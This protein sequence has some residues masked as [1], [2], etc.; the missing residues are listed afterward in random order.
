MR[1]GVDYPIQFDAF[2]LKQQK[3]SLKRKQYNNTNLHYQ[4]TYEKDFLD[5]YYDN[6]DIVNGPT[7]KYK[8]NNEN[9]VYFSDFYIKS[10]NIIVEIKSEYYYNLH[11]K[12]NLSKKEECIKQGYNFIFIINKDY[13]EL[14]EILKIK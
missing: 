7:I 10:K 13:Y 3:T 12:R 5:E 2:Y 9:K 4:G 1:Y 8:F 14:N 6:I 11:L